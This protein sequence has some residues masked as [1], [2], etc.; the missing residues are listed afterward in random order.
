MTQ[1]FFSWGAF[2]ETWSGHTRLF[3]APFASSIG[4]DLSG[5][6]F[7]SF[8]QIGLQATNFCLLVGPTQPCFVQT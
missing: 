7:H 3:R 2:H 5:I 1:L 6:F 8:F 4:V